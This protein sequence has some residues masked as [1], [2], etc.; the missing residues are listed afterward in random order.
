MSTQSH[1]RLQ[2][3]LCINPARLCVLCLAGEVIRGSDSRDVGQRIISFFKKLIE[4]IVF[5]FK[6]IIDPKASDDFVQKQQRSAARAASS[7]GT[8]GKAAQKSIPRRPFGGP[9]R[10]M[11]LGDLRDASG[12]CAAGA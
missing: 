2:Y 3:F 11:G 7:S 12:N 1:V 10:I 9:G 5:F 6:T 8:G 4:I